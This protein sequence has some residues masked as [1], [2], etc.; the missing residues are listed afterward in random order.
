[1]R[2]D[3]WSGVPMLVMIIV[4]M[5]ALMQESLVKMFVLLFFGEMQ[6]EPLSHEPRCESELDRESV[7]RHP[8]DHP[9]FSNCRHP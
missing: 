4:H 6:P 8:T 5:P 1:M 3:Y 9:G 2:L 7:F